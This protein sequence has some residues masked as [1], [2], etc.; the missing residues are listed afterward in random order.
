MAQGDN[1]Q[2][3]EFFSRYGR[4]SATMTGTRAQPFE[5][6]VAVIGL[7]GAL[8]HSQKTIVLSASRLCGS[9]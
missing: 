8:R 5:L 1:Q 4:A 7:F 6:S 3:N 2:D 9:R